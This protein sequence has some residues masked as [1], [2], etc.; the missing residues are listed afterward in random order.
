MFGSRRVITRTRDMRRWI[1]L[2]IVGAATLILAVVVRDFVREIVV[3]PVAYL[4]W[5]VWLLLTNLPHWI[6]WTLLLL[7][8]LV[9][10]A[11]SLRRRPARRQQQ[12]AAKSPVQGPVQRWSRLFTQAEQSAS[13][14]QR[15]S[16]E[17]GHVLWSAQHPDLPYNSRQFAEL[18]SAHTPDS[19]P[20]ATMRAYFAAGLERPQHRNAILV[21]RQTS[22]WHT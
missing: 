16:R 15:L 12:P 3:E 6:F 2:A 22:V 7:A 19:G 13:A 5:I 20:D 8:G 21:V 17:L 4:G 9:I 1:P 18:S 11:S 14:R 10:A